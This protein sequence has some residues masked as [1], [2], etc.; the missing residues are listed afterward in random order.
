MKL[1]NLL[2]AQIFLTQELIKKLN[3]KTAEGLIK[4]SFYE[5]VVSGL[6]S[7][8]SLNKDNEEMN[9]QELDFNKRK[10]EK[11]EFKK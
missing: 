9:A 3:L 1:E 11:N 5:G 6:L 2:R 10:G 8:I 7:S 4:K